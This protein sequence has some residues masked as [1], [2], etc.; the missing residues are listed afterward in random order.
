M[1]RLRRNLLY[2][3]LLM[4]YHLTMVSIGTE[5]DE[6]YS[7]RCLHDYYSEKEGIISYNVLV[8]GSSLEE[9]EGH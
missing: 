3:Y 2:S 1:L 6:L 7:P 8:H 9:T 4:T 5:R